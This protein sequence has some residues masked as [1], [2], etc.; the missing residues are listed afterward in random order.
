MRAIQPPLIQRACVR[1]F[2]RIVLRGLFCAFGKRAG[3]AQVSKWLGYR[4]H[5]AIAL[6]SSRAAGERRVLALLGVEF[7]GG[8]VLRY[9]IYEW[10]SPASAMV[11]FPI[12]ILLI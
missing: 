9:M 1:V 10:G 4:M 8:G 11:V 12:Y 5:G 7:I 3:F 2:G 6:R